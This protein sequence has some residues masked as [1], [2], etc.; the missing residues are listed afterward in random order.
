MPHDNSVLLGALC[1]ASLLPL[2]AAPLAAQEPEDPTPVELPPML[3]IG[4][5]ADEAVPEVPLQAVGSRDVLGP[6]DIEAAG[7]RDV[8]DL[9]QNLPAL[10]TRPYNGGE[11]AAPS[12]SA[13]GLPDDGLTEY[14]HVLIDGVPASPMPYGWTAFSFFPLPPERIHAIDYM[15]GAH[16]VR[17][18][19]NSVGGVLNFV[20]HP[21]PSSGEVGVRTT[22]G[23]HGYTS[24]MLTGG[25]SDGTWSWRLTHVDREGDGYRE[26]G[27]FAQEDIHLKLRRELADG[28]WLA[29]SFGYMT[30]EHKAPGG[31][32]QA[33]YAFDP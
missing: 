18:S 9:L 6:E 22:V 25:G 7:A 30:S 12:F 15:R 3:V 4:R 5:S 21:L 13:R 16:S 8:N 28:D 26:G 32:T 2:F 17:Y 11:A 33:Q 1:S 14:I 19:P 29:A 20:T 27:E 23:T 10:S 31:L 24:D